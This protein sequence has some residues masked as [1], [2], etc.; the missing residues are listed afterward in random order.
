MH[1]GLTVLAQMGGGAGG[2]PMNMLITMGLIFAIFYFML[3]R[4]Q[5]RKEKARKKTIETL[6]AGQRVL[7]AAGL[8][9]TIT[10]AREYTFLI[11]IAKGVTIEVA[12]GAVTK[13]LEAGDKP[14][15]EETR[16]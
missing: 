8:I 1:N 11:E 3:I 5:Q 6:R 2:N 14:T 10:E 12:R 16:G 13:M 7:F 15:V 4:P 9:G